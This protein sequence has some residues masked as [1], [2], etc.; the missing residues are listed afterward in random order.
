[1]TWKRTSSPLTDAQKRHICGILSVGCDRQ[2]AADC[3][4]SSLASIRREMERDATFLA[5]VLRAEAGVELRHM[6]NVHDTAK[7]KKEWRASVWWLE[8][9]SP[10]RFARRDPG[11][12]TSRQLKTF[13]TLLVDV[14]TDAVTCEADR[15]RV[16]THLESIADSVD[17]LLSDSPPRTDAAP[18]TSS[19]VLVQ[20]LIDFD[21][22]DPA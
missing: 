6:Q 12:I 7:E 9:R 21:G 17:Q 1:M 20:R 11:A 8:R 2:T 22:A 18:S 13:V 10:E 14:L 4:G 16:L 3:V 15:D 5:G 19:A